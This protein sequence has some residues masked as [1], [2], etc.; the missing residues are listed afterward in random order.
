MARIRA[1]ALMPD[2]DKALM[3]EL[4]PDVARELGVNPKNFCL[5]IFFGTFGLWATEVYLAID[6]FERRAAEREA[7]R[8]KEKQKPAPPASAPWPIVC[9][10]P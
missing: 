6:D 1:S 2:D 3:V 5:A 8:E 10:I 4:S 9:D 7:K